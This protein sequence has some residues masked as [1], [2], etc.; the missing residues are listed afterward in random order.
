MKQDGDHDKGWTPPL[1]AQQEVQALEWRLKGWC[2]EG[3]ECMYG[4]HGLSGPQF[5][6]HQAEKVKLDRGPKTRAGLPYLLPLALLPVTLGRVFPKM[7]ERDRNPISK[8]MQQR[9]AT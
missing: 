1:H 6:G 7:E 2:R 9:F 8:M 5:H 3:S 4:S